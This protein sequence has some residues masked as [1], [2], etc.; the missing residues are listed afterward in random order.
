MKNTSPNDVSAEGAFGEDSKTA[1]KKKHSLKDAAGSVNENHEAEL[2]T[3]DKI[4]KAARKIFLEKGFNDTKTRDIAA[5]ANVNL[6]LVNYYFRSKDKLFR[7]IFEETLFAI[8]RNILAIFESDLPLEEKL[9]KVSEKYTELFLKDPDMPL[10]IVNENQRRADEM[11][12]KMGMATKSGSFARQLKE[13]AEKGNIR[14][15][16]A[17]EIEL[18]CAAL[19]MFP[20]M[21]RSV[22]PLNGI[23]GKEAFEKLVRERQKMVPEMVMGYLKIR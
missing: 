4:K 2:S 15:T 1:A 20:F 10:F 7:E 19:I 8:N 16:T 12:K 3:E 6:A 13:E 18:T 22:M 21:A 11:Y 9:D 5:A 14:P 17:F 23:V